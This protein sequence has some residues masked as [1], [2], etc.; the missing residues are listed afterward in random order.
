MAAI[1]K[2][3][4]ATKADLER[5]LGRLTKTVSGLGMDPEKLAARVRSEL[6]ATWG[7]T[8]KRLTEVQEAVKASGPALSRVTT[9]L[10]EVTVAVA[11]AEKGRATQEQAAAKHLADQALSTQGLQNQLTNLGTSL[12]AKLEASGGGAA[13]HGEAADRATAASIDRLAHDVAQL[14]LLLK[15]LESTHGGAHGGTHGD[16]HSGGGGA[17][18]DI[19]ELSAVDHSGGQRSHHIEVRRHC[20][21]PP[22]HYCYPSHHPTSPPSRHT[23]IPPYHHTAITPYQHNTITP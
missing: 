20:T 23:A 18:I 15:P 16:A 8:D 9:K 5:E 22:S 21:T 1:A 7:G 12:S 13:S 6:D 19:S 11:E 14:A 4:H 3:Q 10:E 17:H 2:E